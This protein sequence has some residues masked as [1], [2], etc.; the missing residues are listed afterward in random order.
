MGIL[1]GWPS[2]RAHYCLLNCFLI[3][4]LVGTSF[5]SCDIMHLLSEEQVISKQLREEAEGLPLGVLI[6]ADFVDKKTM[7]FKFKPVKDSEM[8]FFMFNKH[9]K[10]RVFLNNEQKPVYESSKGNAEPLLFMALKGNSY[11]FELEFVQEVHQ[12]YLYEGSFFID[13]LESE[14]VKKVEATK[15]TGV[16]IFRTY[17]TSTSIP[18]TKVT[19]YR[20]APDGS[21]L[22]TTL[23]S[24]SYRWRNNEFLKL[25]LDKDALLLNPLDI[26]ENQTGTIYVVSDN[27]NVAVINNSELSWVSPGMLPC[28][29]VFSVWN[30]SRN[31]SYFAGNEALCV[32]IDNFWGRI[33]YEGY[34]EYDRVKDLQEDKNQTLYLSTNRSIFRLDE[35]LSLLD[36]IGKQCAPDGFKV[37]SQGGIYFYCD[38]AIHYYKDEKVTPIEHPAFEQII[39]VFITSEGTPVVLTG[40]WTGLILD[41]KVK[42]LSDPLITES[43]NQVV[44]MDRDLYLLGPHQLLKLNSSDESFELLKTFSPSLQVPFILKQGKTLLVGSRGGDA[45]FVYYFNGALWQSFRPNGI[46]NN[47]VRSLA[48]TSSNQVLIGT[49]AGLSKL[50]FE[51]SEVSITPIPF[52]DNEVFIVNDMILHGDQILVYSSFKEGENIVSYDPVKGEIETYDKSSDLSELQHDTGTLNKIKKLVSE[53]FDERCQFKILYPHTIESDHL[54]QPIYVSCGEGEV[55]FIEVH[56]ESIVPVLVQEGEK[57]LTISAVEKIPEGPL[58]LGANKTSYIYAYQNSEIQSV[59][60]IWLGDE[61]QI[62][63]LRRDNA[64]RLFIGT[65]N[66]LFLSEVFKNE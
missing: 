3:L 25:P 42:T 35:S 19:G 1:L 20:Q 56:G 6:Y 14:E 38:G 51:E 44:E 23:E 53:N 59:E 41:G 15:I 16:E 39:D 48:F 27:G 22:I 13:Y 7:W 11:Y 52:A 32:E 54:A 62:N 40:S 18:G 33:K 8:G 58:L 47:N 34:L 55:S 36:E 29:K 61:V 9:V 65:T 26:S 46:Q 21:Y 63:I 64:N 37:D 43:F 30:D 28:G 17:N 66:G 57:I 24:G 12:T 5:F 31:V 45:Q 50:V 49:D 2:Y 10:Y 60:G 4:F